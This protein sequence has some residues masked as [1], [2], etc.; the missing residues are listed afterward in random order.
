METYDLFNIFVKPAYMLHLHVVRCGIG[1]NPDGGSS[2]L[3][4]ADTRLRDKRTFRE[5]DISKNFY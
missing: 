2:G 3:P 1:N 5:V 4:R